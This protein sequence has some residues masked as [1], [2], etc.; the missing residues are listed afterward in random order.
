VAKA[1]KPPNPHDALFRRTFEDVAHAAAELRAVLPPALVAE[2]DL[3]ALELVSGSFIDE[4][5][6]SS[7]SDLLF[8]TRFRG[9]PARIYLLFEH[10]SQVDVL[11]AL[12]LLKYVVN[13]LDRHVTESG[14]GR[15]ALPLPI[16]IPVVLHHSTRGWTAAT[17]LEDLFPPQLARNPAIA[18]YVPRLSF[19]LDDISRLS[20]AAL[21]RRA[22]GLLPTLTLWA[23][24]DSRRRHAVQ[25]SLTRYA[26]LLQA[27]DKST[28]GA[29]TFMTLFRYL[30]VVVRD[31]KPQTFL[32]TVELSEQTKK[33]IMTTM[34]DHWRAEGR[35]EHAQDTLL[36]QLEIKFGPLAPNTRARILAAKGAELD[37]WLGRVVTA[38]SLDELLGPLGQS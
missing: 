18:A 29:E 33:V 15:A 6:A 34:A 9:H 20:D 11:M 24:R 36:T 37:R 30:A 10:Q 8:A 17:R 2:L 28:N 27:L 1:P 35:T 32:A 19:V 5:L 26:P 4:E 25:R 7:Q 12:R 21:A 14:G 16:V 38:G 3:S 13:V 31:F 23:L 22:L